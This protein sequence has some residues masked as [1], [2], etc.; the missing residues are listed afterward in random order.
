[1]DDVETAE[2]LR[3][4]VTEP[5]KHSPFEWPTDACGYD[6]QVRFVQYRKDHWKGGTTEELMAFVLA[7]ADKL[8]TDALKVVGAVKYDQSRQ[9]QSGT[10]ISAVTGHEGGKPCCTVQIAFKGSQQA[11]TGLELDGMVKQFCKE[12][13]GCFGVEKLE[14][15]QGKRCYALRCWGHQGDLIEG[16]ASIDTNKVFTLTGWRRRQ[17]KLRGAVCPSPLE[18]ARQRIRWKF[19]GLARDLFDCFRDLSELRDGYKEWEDR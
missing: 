19:E 12:L 14:E 11:F 1:M 10:I 6:Q 9:R 3:R 15:L 8:M 5:Y 16:L 4:W 7:Y 13:C 17:L 18:V 2:H